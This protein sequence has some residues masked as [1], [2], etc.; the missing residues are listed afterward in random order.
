MKKY[1]AWYNVTY[2]HYL[3]IIEANSIEEAREKALN[4]L[5]MSRDGYNTNETIF[6]DEADE[7]D[8][9]A[10]K[11]QY[12][13][14]L[15]TIDGISEIAEEHQR[16]ID[17]HT[18]G[19]HDSENTQHTEVMPHNDVPQQGACDSKGDC[20]QHDERLGKRFKGNGQ[21]GVDAHN[22]DGKA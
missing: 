14:E 7:G 15:Q 5:P 12:N 21:E 3:G 2:Y 8:E 11:K 22:G 4:K 18:G 6:V 17:H 9:E 20:R 1:K 10:I 19:T 13:V 16:I